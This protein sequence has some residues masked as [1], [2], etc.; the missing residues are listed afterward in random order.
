MTV[1]ATSYPLRMVVETIKQMIPPLSATKTPS[2]TVDTITIPKLSF[3]T[4][5]AVTTTPS[6]AGLSMWMGS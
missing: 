4:S 2:A 1:G 6:G 5:R 3:T